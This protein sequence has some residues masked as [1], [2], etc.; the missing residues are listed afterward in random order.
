MISCSGRITRVSDARCVSHI[1]LCPSLYSLTLLPPQ[2]YR[3]FFAHLT[4]SITEMEVYL[5]NNKSLQELRNFPV[6]FIDFKKITD[7]L[8]KEKEATEKA[9]KAKA[10][11]QTQPQAGG[12][13]SSR[14]RNNNSN[15]RR[16]VSFA[17]APTTDAAASGASS[18]NGADPDN[19][20]DDEFQSDKG[21][22][23][24]KDSFA[25]IRR[26]K[27]TEKRFFDLWFLSM[28]HM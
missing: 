23:N 2:I 8:S 26:F 4:T 9:K 7:R 27:L 17:P 10:Q 6:N 20:A 12:S 13:V 25:L 1:S 16:T 22:D 14:T 21:D 28:T 19:D 11:A 24:S 18:I 5:L 15:R 3:V